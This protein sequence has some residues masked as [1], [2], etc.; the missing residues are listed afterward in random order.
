MYIALYWDLPATLMAYCNLK[1]LLALNT[2]K[3]YESPMKHETRNPIKHLKTLST[4][5]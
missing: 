4:K 2:V 3:P 5:P 1:I